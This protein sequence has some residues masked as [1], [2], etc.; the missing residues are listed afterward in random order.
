[1]QVRY[2]GV[3]KLF[4]SVPALND[5]NLEV[6]DGKFLALL[7]PSG[8]GKTT[9]LRILAGL[10]EPSSG[11]VYIGDR[12][13]TRLEPRARDVAMVFQSYALYPH[14]SVSDNIA[15]P[16]R[17]RKVDKKTRQERV[18]QVA[19]MLSITPLLDRMP[20][21]LSGGQRQRVALARAIVREPRAFLMDEPLSNLDAQLR[22]QMRIEIKRLQRELG[23]TTLYVTHDQ[24]EAMTMADLVAVMHDG[25]LQQLAAPADLY[26][27]PANL[28]VARF[29]G[30]P[31]MNVVS[32]D[33]ADGVFEHPAGK[34][35]LG[36][37]DHRGPAKLGFRPEHAAMVDP[38]TDG[39]LA[40]EVYVVEPLG[41]ET[42]IALRLGDD[43]INLRAAA[44]VNPAVGSACGVLPATGHLHLFDV[45]SGDAIPQHGPPTEGAE[46]ERQPES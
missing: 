35:A 15:Y 22:L 40:A 20:R 11:H 39:A 37:S 38:G 5:L 29:C 6:P 33:V 25:E 26:A 17:I 1:M 23:I 44:T 43:L 13:V 8:C 27:H 12:D 28:F 4:G 19:E 2:D 24:V 34:V 41:N 45:D 16:L 9:A 3:G 32:G 31:P 21:Q 10:E 30:S 42:L 7:G 36:R 46:H 14:K 18:A